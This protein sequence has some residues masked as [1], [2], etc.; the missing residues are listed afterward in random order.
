MEAGNPPTT[1]QLL[2]WGTVR[3]KREEGDRNKAKRRT[4]GL[5][6]REETRI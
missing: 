3:G 6:E 4:M 1:D 2:A 5:E